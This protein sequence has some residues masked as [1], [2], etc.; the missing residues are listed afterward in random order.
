VRP[1]STC[2]GNRRKAATEGVAPHAALVRKGRGLSRKS[3]KVV[4]VRRCGVSRRVAV[5]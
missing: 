5:A 4:N 1:L 2:T 3:G